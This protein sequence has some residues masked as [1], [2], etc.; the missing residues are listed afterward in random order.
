RVLRGVHVD[1]RAEPF[2]DLR[3]N[4]GN[5]DARRGM[6]RVGVARHLHDVGITGERPEAGPLLERRAGW[7][8]RLGVEAH[9]PLG[10]QL[11]EDPLAVGPEP[12]F[13]LAELDVV[14]SE[15]RR[16]RRDGGHTSP[17]FGM[18][19]GTPRSVLANSPSAAP[20][21]VSIV[22]GLSSS[23]SVIGRQPRMSCTWP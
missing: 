9:R 22:H 23:A 7:W 12:M 20:F 4:V 16:R 2:G 6:E 18:N 17:T 8:Y 11:G 13:D 14:E 3:G 1:H 10:A 21:T 19:G 15:I 5:V